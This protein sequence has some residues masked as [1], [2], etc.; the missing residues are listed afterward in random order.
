MKTEIYFFSGTGNSLHIARELQKKIPESELRPIIMV[1][2]QERIITEAEVIGFVFPNFCLTIPI[3]L[4][5]LLLK[6][7]LS[8]AR[9]IFAVCTR[10]GS[11]SEALE[12][13]NI[14]LKKQRKQVH[15]YV[16]IT[17]PWNNPMGKG[18]TC[19]VAEEELQEMETSLRQKLDVLCVHIAKQ[20]E[21]FPQDSDIRLKLPLWARL[22]NKVITKK[23]NFISHRHMYQK[24]V[25][26]YSNERCVGC[27]TCEKVC[28]T[29]RI[30][31]N[32][33]KPFWKPQAKCYACFACINFCPQEAIQIASRFPFKSFTDKNGRYHHASVTPKDIAAQQEKDGIPLK[34]LTGSYAAGR[35]EAMTY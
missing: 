12:F 35:M 5:E 29:Q 26:F 19:R 24:M 17:M 20:T 28:P 10:G 30:E 1:V 3:P 31:L 6:A 11:E 22:I 33:R 21:Y 25:H 16:N 18:Y 8:S 7:D 27:G 2:K 23:S 13:M 14:L 34:K 9:Y 32:D 4:Y 15:A